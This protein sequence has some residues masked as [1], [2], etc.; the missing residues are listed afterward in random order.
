[1]LSA[2]QIK[3]TLINWL[4]ETKEPYHLETP[5]EIGTDP[6]EFGIIVGSEENKIMIY[7]PRHKKSRIVFNMH[8]YFTEKQREIIK[9]MGKEDFSNFILTLT[10]KMTTYEVYWTI[11]GESQDLIDLQMFKSID[12]S[13]LTKDRFYQTIE[14]CEVVKS[15]IMRTIIHLLRSDEQMSLSSGSTADKPMYG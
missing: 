4:N 3:D 2:V 5:D 14:R 9:S 10:D 6:I 7:V 13:A 12:E 11:Q 1:M 8:I 15:Q